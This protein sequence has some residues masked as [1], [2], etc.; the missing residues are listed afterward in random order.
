MHEAVLPEQSHT[1]ELLKL[2]NINTTAVYVTVLAGPDVLYEREGR[3]SVIHLEVVSVTGDRFTSND[4]RTMCLSRREIGELEGLCQR[5]LRLL[6]CTY[7]PSAPPDE[8]SFRPGV[9]FIDPESDEVHITF[10]LAYPLPN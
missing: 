3:T 4:L 7:L 1:P 2:D 8:V 6:A 5:R 10:F 9:R